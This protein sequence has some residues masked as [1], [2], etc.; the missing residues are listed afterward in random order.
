MARNNAKT[1]QPRC[2]QSKKTTHKFQVESVLAVNAIS[3]A[4]SIDEGE[5]PFWTAL[6]WFECALSEITDTAVTKPR[7]DHR[8]NSVF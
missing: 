4:N 5:N 3:L 8:N 1:P 6:K 2:Y 7:C